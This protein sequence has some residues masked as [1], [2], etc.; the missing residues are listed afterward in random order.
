[1]AI[2][3]AA[4]LY[5]TGVAVADDNYI[6][7]NTTG[8]NLPGVTLPQGHD[9]V[10]A[11]DGTTCRSAVGGNGGYF[12]MGLIG[13]P[14]TE[15]SSDG[16]VSAYGRVVFQ[17][18]AN[19]P[20][21]DCTRLYDLELARLEMELKLMQMGLGRGMA[22]VGSGSSIDPVPLD[23]A[24]ASGTPPVPGQEGAEEIKVAKLEKKKSGSDLED[25]WAD[26]GWS[27]DGLKKRK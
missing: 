6:Q 21:V 11:A 24:T 27:T 25:D 20:R 16:S 5:M 2:L 19:R 9:E 12:D 26:E 4:P 10:R 13:N 3:G 15:S 23:G 18:G 7:Q 14:E 1:M 8:F 17:F 22:P